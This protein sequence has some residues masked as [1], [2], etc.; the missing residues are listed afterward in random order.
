MKPASFVKRGV[1][2]AGYRLVEWLSPRLP[3]RTVFRLADRLAD[4]QWRRSPRAR[5]AVEANLSTFFEAAAGGADRSGRK[6]FRNFARYLV[7][8]FGIRRGECPALAVEGGSHLERCR[9]FGRGAI[10]LTG[11][12]GNWELGAVLIRRMGVPV[13]VVALPHPDP[14]TD[15]LFT[16]QR[17]RCGLGVIPLGAG[18][19]RRS[20]RRLNEGELLGLPGDW[21]F[22]GAG[23]TVPFGGGSLTMPR[24]PAVL[25][26]RSGAPVLPVFLIRE[27]DW[28]FRLF[29]EPPIWPGDS[30]RGE[31]AVRSL[32]RRYAGVI[33]RYV[34]RFPEQWLIFHEAIQPL[35]SGLGAHGWG[36]V[37]G[38]QNPEPSAALQ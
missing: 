1:A 14:R 35:D 9:A 16:R 6:V 28:A 10:L 5:A 12:L 33:E 3:L 38:V 17:Q 30:E 27:G 4:V 29:I 21:D 26:L 13:T 37:P 20:L 8:F 11:H 25:S 32:T 7:E 15:R 24:G 2:H 36:H 23:L 22:T 31:A 34:R 19:A 18:V